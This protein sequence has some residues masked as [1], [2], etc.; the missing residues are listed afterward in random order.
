MD[1]LDARE[2]LAVSLRPHAALHIAARMAEL[3]QQARRFGFADMLERL[4]RALDPA[5]NG[6]QPSGCARSSWRGIRWR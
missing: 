5:R 4:D 1:A 3:K 2:P 6:A